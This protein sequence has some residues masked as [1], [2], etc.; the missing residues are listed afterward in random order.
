[1]VDT[2]CVAHTSLKKHLRSTEEWSGCST[3]EELGNSHSAECR[4]GIEKARLALVKRL[5]Q[6]AQR[7]LHMRQLFILIAAFFATRWVE[8]TMLPKII[9]TCLARFL[10][11]EKSISVT[12]ADPGV[13]RIHS[14]CDCRKVFFLFFDFCDFFLIFFIF[15]IF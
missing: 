13:S 1:M 8:S 15:L 3:C 11:F 9:K 7:P 12:Q 6:D 14:G 2:W 5:W 4:T 10:G